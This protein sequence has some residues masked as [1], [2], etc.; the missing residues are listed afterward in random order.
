M[1]TKM[2]EIVDAVHP[3]ILF[4]HF[5]INLATI[6]KTWQISPEIDEPE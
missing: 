6:E 2:L 1:G 3:S 5:V 4:E